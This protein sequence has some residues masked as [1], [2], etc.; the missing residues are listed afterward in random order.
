MK[1]A[2]SVALPLSI[3]DNPIEQAWFGESLYHYD[4]F[5]CDLFYFILFYYIIVN[6]VCIYIQG[7]IDTVNLSGVFISLYIFSASFFRLLLPPRIPPAEHE[8]VLWHVNFSYLWPEWLQLRSLGTA[9][10]CKRLS[11][12]VR[13]RH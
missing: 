5:Y 12:S 2:A 1:H 7:Y 11:S 3:H 8:D 10:R 9:L 4:I 6:Y 13:L